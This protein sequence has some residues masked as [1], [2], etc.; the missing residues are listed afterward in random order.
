MSIIEVQEFFFSVVGQVLLSGGG[1]AAVAFFVFKALGKGWLQNEF[2]KDLEAAKSEIALLLARRIK[3]H[4]REYVV[5]PEMWK[6]LITVQSNLGG[7]LSSLRPYFGLDEFP[8]EAFSDWL[9]STDLS[10]SERNFLST[11]PNKESAYSRILSAQAINQARDD[12]EDF[13]RCFSENRIFLSPEL[14]EKLSEVDEV[15]STVLLTK[16]LHF[17]G[18]PSPTDS[19]L[20]DQ[21]KSLWIKEVKPKIIEIEAI[22]QAK[23]F[24]ADS[25][26]RRKTK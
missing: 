25:T 16:T 10:K 26:P 23:L 4:D 20:H 14:Q 19:N 2:S 6:K 3:L 5:F 8:P 22:M 17:Q 12:Y 9:K 11:A 7:T 15:I 13:R 21:A 18:V 1:G 24:P